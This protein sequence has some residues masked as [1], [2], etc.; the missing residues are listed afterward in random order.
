[1]VGWLSITVLITR[2][3]GGSKQGQAAWRLPPISSACYFID[4][5]LLVTM[6]S[7][8]L[9]SVPTFSHRQRC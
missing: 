3:Q 2:R 5:G 9:F 6:P 8:L 1:M 4:Y 7:H